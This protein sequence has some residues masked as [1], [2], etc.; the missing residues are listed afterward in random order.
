MYYL[1]IGFFNGKTKTIKTD[2]LE[3]AYTLMA[4]LKNKKNVQY[5]EII[6]SD[7]IAR[8]LRTK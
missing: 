3:E 2:S 5:T 4:I 7:K 6:G 1:E 8:C